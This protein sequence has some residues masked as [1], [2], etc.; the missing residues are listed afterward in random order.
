MEALGILFIGLLLVIAVV[1]AG[2]ILKTT[3]IGAAE[4][5]A[6]A[7]P[8][9]LIGWIFFFPLML[10][11]S[12]FW[13]LSNSLDEKIDAS[14]HR[15]AVERNKR[16]KELADK[17]IIDHWLDKVIAYEAKTPDNSRT[18]YDFDRFISHSYNSAGLLGEPPAWLSQRHVTLKKSFLDGL[19][20]LEATQ[21]ELQS[22]VLRARTEK[23]FKDENPRLI[24]FFGDD[25][26]ENPQWI[27]NESTDEKK[28]QQEI[29]EQ[30]RKR[31]LRS[32]MNLNN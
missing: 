5:F 17:N 3:F 15:S 21:E 2:W 19:D 18:K 30:K 1:I 7:G 16:N 22:A 11:I 20:Y 31:D 23:D 4:M 32:K 12:F 6:T 13:A 26:P 27:I 25:Y 8:I 9:V 24:A 28:R 10:A 29:E 14:E